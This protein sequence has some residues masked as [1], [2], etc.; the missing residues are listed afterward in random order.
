MP[1]VDDRAGDSTPWFSNRLMD[2]YKATERGL[3]IESGNYSEPHYFT[4]V[5]EFELW[6][7]DVEKHIGLPLGRK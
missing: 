7:G 3:I 5:S 2:A 4:Q 6:L 1:I